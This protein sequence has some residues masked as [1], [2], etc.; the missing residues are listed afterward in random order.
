MADKCQCHAWPAAVRHSLASSGGMGWRAVWLSNGSERWQAQPRGG[1]SVRCAQLLCLASVVLLAEVMF[2]RSS[3]MQAST[4]F[5]GCLALLTT[6]MIL[7][8]AALSLVAAAV[9][10]LGSCS[11]TPAPCAVNNFLKPPGELWRQQLTPHCAW[12]TPH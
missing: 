3:I 1:G 9:C 7:S 12:C 10:D 5:C 8:P 2:P 4:P 6:I 11:L